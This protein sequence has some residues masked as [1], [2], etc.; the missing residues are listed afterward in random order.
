MWPS[1]ND[2]VYSILSGRPI[3][4]AVSFRIQKLKSSGPDDLFVV[5]F[6]NLSSTVC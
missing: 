3:E 2:L 6:D 5:N 1:V 4:D